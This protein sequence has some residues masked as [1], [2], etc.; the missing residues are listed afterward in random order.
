[1]KRS[2]QCAGLFLRAI[3]G[4]TKIEQKASSRFQRIEESTFQLLFQQITNNYIE[5]KKKKLLTIFHDNAIN[6][7]PNHFSECSKCNKFQLLI[8]TLASR[9]N[10]NV[11]G[12]LRDYFC[13]FFTL[14]RKKCTKN[15][16]RA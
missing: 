14:V 4:K 11:S 5:D 8:S 10:D 15:N 3:C 16:N 7:G 6:I 2:N 12:H 13:Y 1:M 9:M